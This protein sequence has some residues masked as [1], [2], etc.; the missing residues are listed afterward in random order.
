MGRRK[1]GF[2]WNLRRLMAAQDLWKTTELIPLLRERGVELSPSQVYRL[3]TDKPERLSLTVLIALCDIL[4]CTPTDLIEHYVEA[5][6]RRT[7]TADSATVVDLK[8][9]LRPERARILDED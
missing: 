8:P 3:V 7:A 1:L 6:T 9:D 2:H 5:S 4:D